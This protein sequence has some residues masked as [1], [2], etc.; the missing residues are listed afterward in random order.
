MSMARVCASFSSYLWRWDLSSRSSSDSLWS[1]PCT[2][3]WHPYMS[4]Y[5]LRAIVEYGY[6]ARQI[7]SCTNSRFGAYVRTTPAL[8]RVYAHERIRRPVF[9]YSAN[10]S[11]K[12]SGSV[13]T[14]FEWKCIRVHNANVVTELHACKPTKRPCHGIHVPI[15]RPQ[16]G[17]RPIQ[18]HMWQVHVHPVCSIWDIV[19]FA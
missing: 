14:I 9:K 16:K 10:F 11:T 13:V 12:C 3:W 1:R 6:T 2:C 18:N 8:N 4:S 15:E 17:P 7:R 5:T 19:F